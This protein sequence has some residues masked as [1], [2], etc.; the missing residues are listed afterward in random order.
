MT[1]AIDL[2]AERREVQ[3]PHGI[4]VKLNGE[5]FMFPPEIPADCLDP[6]FSDELDLMGVLRDIV[7]A[8]SGTTT[9]GEIIELIFRRPQ[10]PGRFYQAIKDIYKELLGEEPYVE[11]KAARPSIPDYVRLTKAL[12]AVYGVDLGKLFRS[13]SSSASDSATSSPTSPA[14]TDSMPEASGS[15]QDSPGSSD[16]GD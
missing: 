2:D 4:P 8:E 11:F 10:L 3:F 9:S 13:D 1:F 7:N 15:G 5:Q 16:S 6:L 12:V 14:T